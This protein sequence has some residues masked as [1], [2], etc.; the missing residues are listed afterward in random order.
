MT[1]DLLSG[2]L[3]RICLLGPAE[4]FT[5]EV[6]VRRGAELL[7]CHH[8]RENFLVALHVLIATEN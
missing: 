8:T 6:L 2:S 1:G 4:D 7:V 5:G 3:N